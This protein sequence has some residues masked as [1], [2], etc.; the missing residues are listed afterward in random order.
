[1]KLITFISIFL[2]ACNNNPKPVA[3]KQTDSTWTSVLYAMDWNQN[4]YRAS[5]AIKIIRDTLKVDSNN[6]TKNIVVRDTTYF[7]PIFLDSLI[8]GQPVFDSLK[9]KVQ[10][11]QW[12]ILPQKLMLIDYNK[13]WKDIQK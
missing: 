5:T 12:V 11:L 7:V 4:D 3:K 10:I 6:I 9:R 8:N 2:F 13:S 1:M